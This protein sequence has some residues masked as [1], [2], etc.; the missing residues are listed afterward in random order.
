MVDVVVCGRVMY[1]HELS[2]ESFWRWSFVSSLRVRKLSLRDEF[3]IWRMTRIYVEYDWA[4]KVLRMVFRIEFKDFGDCRY[5]DYCY[6][7]VL[8][9][10][11]CV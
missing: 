4:L 9:D 5:G 7:C 3:S 6:L 2:F 10:Y 11:I 1:V 8:G